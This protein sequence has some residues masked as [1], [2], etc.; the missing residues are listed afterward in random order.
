M[1]DVPELNIEKATAHRSQFKEYTDRVYQYDKNFADE[2]NGK[3][4]VLV[5]GNSFARDMVN[6]LLESDYRDKINI[7]YSN[8][9][10]SADTLIPRIKKSDYIFFF[11]WKHKLAEFVMANKKDSAQIWGIGTKNF[12]S[13]IGPIYKNRH[14]PDYFAQTRKIDPNFYVINDMLKAEWGDNYV[15]LLS[16]IENP[17]KKVRIFT[18]E[19]KLLSQDCR[20]LTR[21]GAVFYARQVDFDNIFGGKDN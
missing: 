20:H 1:R 15:D 2:D 4:N 19:H 21:A 3:L 13:S 16:V 8:K 11:G 9:V 7:S 5:L 18:D 14:K 6:I 10:N 17:D 12:G